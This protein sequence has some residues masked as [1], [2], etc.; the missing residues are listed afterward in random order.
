M[1]LK[2][3]F[4]ATKVLIVISSLLVVACDEN[5]GFV[6]NDDITT[7]E[8]MDN[9]TRDFDDESG[10]VSALEDDY[11]GPDA[12]TPLTEAQITEAQEGLDSVDEPES[13]F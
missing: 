1:K 7:E 8:G 11:V 9:V 6:D 4:S 13:I 10:V 5:S 2:N 3:F 12:S